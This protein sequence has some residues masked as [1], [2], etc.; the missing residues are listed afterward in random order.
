MAN[1]RDAHDPCRLYIGKRSLGERRPS[2]KADVALH[3]EDREHEHR[4][5]VPS[6]HDRDEHDG[7]EQSRQ[8]DHE[9]DHAHGDHV[10]QAPQ[11]AGRNAHEPGHNEPAQRNYERPDQRRVRP[12][13]KP[14]VDVASEFVGAQ[15]VPRRRRCSEVERVRRVRGPR[16]EVG[17]DE[18]REDDDKYETEAEHYPYGHAFLATRGYRG[19]DRYYRHRIPLKVTRGSIDT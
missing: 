17:T 6:L 3:V 4:H 5:P 15:P 8:R 13:D 16:E 2:D 9:V 18:G 7:Q 12:D 10:G 14:R 1:R 11:I 19:D